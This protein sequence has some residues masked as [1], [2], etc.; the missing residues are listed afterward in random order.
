MRYGLYDARGYDYPVEKRYDTWWRATAGPS[1]FFS[2]PT[3]EALATPAA[4]RGMSLLSV[5]DVIQDPDDPP[6]RLPGLERVYDGPDARVY[7]NADALPRAFLVERQRVV[8]GEEA[9]LRATKSPLFDPR[10][11]AVTEEFLPGIPPAAKPGGS[12]P[13]TAALTSY[14]SERATV[15]TRAAR[16]SLAVLT[17]VHYPGWKATVDGEP[18]DVERVDYLLRG[19]VVPPGR[20]EVEFFY[21]PASWRVGWLVSAVAVLGL[22]A[23]TAV[24][25]RRRRGERQPT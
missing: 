23:A 2:V 25:V 6:S 24:G 18:A 19:V 8:D 17:D 21:E 15:R 13:G 9:A 1:E 12:A 14:G 16:R 10:R 20:H 5:G 3:A 7:R 4:L 11:V 22:L